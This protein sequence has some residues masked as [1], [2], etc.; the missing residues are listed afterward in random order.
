[1]GDYGAESSRSVFRSFEPDLLSV[2]RLQ[3]VL[4]TESLDSGEGITTVSTDQRAL[5]LLCF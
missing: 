4:Y 2:P 3:L 5:L 1:M